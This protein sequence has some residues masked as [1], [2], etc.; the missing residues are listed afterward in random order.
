MNKTFNNP[1]NP[2]TQSQQGYNPSQNK[3]YN[4][5]QNQYNSSDGQ[6]ESDLLARQLE[7]LK[8]SCN[9]EK[10]LNSIN[11]T[12]DYIQQRHS[13]SNKV[14]PAQNNTQVSHGANNQVAQNDDW[15][16]FNSLRNRMNMI[17]R[18]LEDSILGDTRRHSVFRNMIDDMRRDM[19]LFDRNLLSDFGGRSFKD[20]FDY[21][22]QH[23]ES[24]LE[25]YKLDEKEPEDTVGVS[26]QVETHTVNGKT[27]AKVRCE[28]K[29]KDGSK[30]TK[31]KEFND[32][33][34]KKIK[35]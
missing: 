11:Q 7:E 10:T 20:H 28:Y 24:L 5:A 9:D 18:S 14:P 8:K 29:L 12:L 3:D 19:E 17:E 33:D 23:G 34:T 16:F 4:S 26:K 6:R 21:W 35:E 31:E 13:E 15:E 30:I 22:K 27:N 1:S 32:E 25:K 2:Q